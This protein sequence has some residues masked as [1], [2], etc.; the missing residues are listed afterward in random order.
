VCSVGPHNPHS[1]LPTPRGI[2]S[3][4]GAASSG[5]MTVSKHRSREGYEVALTADVSIPAPSVWCE[6]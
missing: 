6:T 3:D 4:D 2:V 1:A 5:R